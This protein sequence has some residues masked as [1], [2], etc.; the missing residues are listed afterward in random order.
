MTS[1]SNNNTNKTS[2]QL[3]D[4]QR[5]KKDND[6]FYQE[7]ETNK[8]KTKHIFKKAQSLMSL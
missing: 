8:Q 7:E 4:S 5:V 2:H 3:Q 1:P 6:T